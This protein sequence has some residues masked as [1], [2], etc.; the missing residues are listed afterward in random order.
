MGRKLS[1]V[2]SNGSVRMVEI[3]PKPDMLRRAVARG[4]VTLK[5]ETLSLIMKGGIPKGN[6]FNTARV[7]GILAAKKVD[8]LIPLCHQLCLTHVSVDFDSCT[9]NKR[10]YIDIEV[11]ATATGKTGV[12]MEA[13]TAVAVAALTI[14]DM[15]KAVDKEMEISDIRLVKKTKQSK[16]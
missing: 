10:A 12:E 4:R 7:A 11:N 3:S 9:K 5:P 14:Y 15:C 6:V 13:L 1:H 8:Q 2:D 16:G